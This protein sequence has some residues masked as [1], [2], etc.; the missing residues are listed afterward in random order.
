MSDLVILTNVRCQ[1]KTSEK[2][3]AFIATAAR[4]ETGTVGLKG[5]KA[6]YITNFILYLYAFCFE[7][8]VH[9]LSLVTFSPK[10]KYPLEEKER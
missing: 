3:N 8:T 2:I 7:N 10:L 6:F 5:L 1:S 4:K 9:E